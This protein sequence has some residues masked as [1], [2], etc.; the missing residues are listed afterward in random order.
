MTARMSNREYITRHCIP[1]PEVA[2]SGKEFAARV[3]RIRMAMAA[4]KIDLLFVSAP[5][6]LY[7][8]SSFLSE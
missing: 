4:T 1:D 7:Y 8:V 3:E 6:G 2:F 5:E